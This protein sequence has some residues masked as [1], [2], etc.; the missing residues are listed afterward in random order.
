MIIMALLE[1]YGKELI[2]NNPEILKTRKKGII[3]NYNGFTIDVLKE[4]LEEVNIIN[5]SDYT[6]YIKHK[7]HTAGFEMKWHIDDA[8]ILKIPDENEHDIALTS[9]KKISYP[10][11]VNKPMYTLIIYE[12]TQDIDFTGGSLCFVNEVINPMK[13]YY[14]FFDSSEPHKLEKIK[15]GIRHSI[16]IKFYY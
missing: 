13:G 2:E 1:K 4:I 14:I 15:S 5:M 10:D 11:P 8:I 16:L 3:S 9:T 12:N 6:Y 7:E